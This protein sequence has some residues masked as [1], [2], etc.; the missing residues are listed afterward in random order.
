MNREFQP[1]THETIFYLVKN[2]FPTPQDVFYDLG[3]GDG[4]VV[5]AFAKAGCRAIGIEKDPNLINLALKLAQPHVDN[6]YDIEIIEG[7]VFDQDLSDGTIFWMALSNNKENEERLKAKLPSGARVVLNNDSWGWPREPG[8][9]IPAGRKVTS[10]EIKIRY[11][12]NAR[13]LGDLTLNE[14]IDNYKVIAQPQ[15]V[16]A[17][18]ETQLTVY[19]VP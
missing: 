8:I 11:E 4:R 13:W 5:Q 2:L 10:Y 7:D 19:R 9:V 17:K 18:N 14:I 16:K 15:F 6:G 12:E 3:C 1:T